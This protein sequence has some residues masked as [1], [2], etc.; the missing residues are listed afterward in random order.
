MRGGKADTADIDANTI[1]QINPAAELPEGNGQLCIV[2]TKNSW[3]VNA[4]LVVSGNILP[5]A[6]QHVEKTPGRLV[7]DEAGKLLGPI[8]TAAPH[9][10]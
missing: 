8:T 2:V 10:P 6:W 9:H 4:K 3:G 7:W 1:L 5:V